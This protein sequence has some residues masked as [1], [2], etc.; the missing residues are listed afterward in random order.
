MAL[1]PCRECGREVSTEAQACPQCGAPA[2]TRPAASTPMAQPSETQGRRT[3]TVIVDRPSS[4]GQRKLLKGLLQSWYPRMTEAELN[5]QL[6][7]EIVWADL[8]QSEANTLMQR[9]HEAG[10]LPRKVLQAPERP[11]GGAEGS[12]GAY[13][14]IG[15]AGTAASRGSK[16]SSERQELTVC[17]ACGR[18]V[19]A[20][21]V[22]CPHCGDRI[23]GSRRPIKGM[24]TGE[25]IAWAVLCFPVGFVKLGQGIKWL[26]WL[27]IVFFT[28]GLGILPMWIDYFMCN[29]KARA[30]GVLGEWEW[31]PRT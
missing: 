29:A 1:V 15:H 17:R 30:T 20:L 6:E 7:R 16:P 24:D 2:P 18:D 28:W 19:S 3:W 31:F 13:G 4:E 5:Q 26:V 21:A 14:R 25:A 27:V 22:T 9:L 23:R 10:L 8:P 12:S 11:T